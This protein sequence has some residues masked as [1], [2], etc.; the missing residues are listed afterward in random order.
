MN[1]YFQGPLIQVHLQKMVL[2]INC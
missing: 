1:W 2:I